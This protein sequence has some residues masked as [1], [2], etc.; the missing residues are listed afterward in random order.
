[1]LRSL[2]T[3]VI[4]GCIAGCAST[5]GGRAQWVPPEELHGVT[6]VY[7]DVGL[8]ARLLIAREHPA[9]VDGGC[10]QNTDLQRRVTDL[11]VQL[12]RA[13]Y[14]RY[15]EVE[16]R[17]PQFKFSVVDKQDA[18]MASSAS[19]EIVLYR[20]LD[21][22]ALTNT[23]LVFLLAREMGHVVLQ[24]HDENVVSGVTMSIL[25]NLLFPVYTVA[26][27]AAALFS[28]STLQGTAIASAASLAG[29]E[30][31]KASFRP[32]QL[33]EADTFAL[34]VLHH[35]GWDCRQVTD[36]LEVLASNAPLTRT[37]WES[38]LRASSI[39]AARLVQGPPKYTE[40]TPGIARPAWQVD[41][42]LILETSLAVD[43]GL[44]LDS[45]LGN[46]SLMS[47]QGRATSSPF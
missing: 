19:G 40:I 2:S 42:G 33:Q 20:G 45:R 11:G 29:S 37:A 34:E 9:C 23:E 31:L 38:E 12:S 3:L 36:S 15:P 28:T 43:S 1:M 5:P 47:T 35:A 46:V 27:G 24:H 7:S 44:A 17:V 13:V 39:H 6:A 21:D 18:S 16:K 25:A 14:S 26:S 8:K 10:A 41:P 22:L 32:L 30:A 4:A